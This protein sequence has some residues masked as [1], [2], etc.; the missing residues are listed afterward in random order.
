MTGH[1]QPESGTN[2]GPAQISERELRENFFPPFEAAVREAGA[3]LVMASYNEIDGV[4]SHVSNWLLQDVLRGEW[5]FR[6]LVVAD[7]YAIEQLVGLHRVA[8]DLRQA[9]IRSLQAGV[10]VDLPNGNAYPALLDALRAGEVQESRIDDAVKRVLTLKFRAGLFEQPFADAT[11]AERLTNNDEA[12][13]LARTAAERG[14]V[15]LKN[16]GM[17]PLRL[18]E[19]GDDTPVIAVIGPNAAVARLGGYYGQPP[20]TVSILDGIRARAGTRAD[21]R[22]AEGVVIT[23]NDDWW[24]D[25]VRLG[26]PAENRRRIAEAVEVARGADAILLALGDTEQTSREGWAESHLGDRTSLDLVGEQQ[27]LFDALRALEIPLTVILINGR[28]ASTVTI[29]NEADALIEGWYL[30]EQGGHAMAGVLFGDI[31]PGGKLPV[32]I[33]RSVG[34]LPMYYNHKPSARRGYLFDTTEP[35]YPFGWGLSYTSFEIGAPRLTKDRI[36][37]NE[38]VD[39]ELVVRNTGAVRG[40]ETVQLYIRDRVASVTRPVKELKAFRRVS[41]EPGEDTTVTFRLTPQSLRFWNDR[42]ERVVEPGEFEIMTGA[43]S[44]DLATVIL[45]V[46]E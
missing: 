42:M 15:L 5:G 2:A 16:D 24:A 33:P 29:A 41:L 43:N 44:V 9:A 40:D 12:R 21:I 39:V 37:R 28:P 27:E 17:L 3:E 38:S 35:L 46:E 8:D 19:A 4:P 26:D 11:Q 45:S 31:N 36:H 32:T 10:D 1:G 20:L 22:F 6:G 18:P 25:E 14:I 13:A 7:Y 30:G 23:E 34:Q